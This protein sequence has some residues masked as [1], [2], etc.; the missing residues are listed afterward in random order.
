MHAYRMRRCD[1]ENCMFHDAL[2][3]SEKQRVL[4]AFVLAKCASTDVPTEHARDVLGLASMQA[5]VDDDLALYVFAYTLAHVHWARAHVSGDSCEAVRTPLFEAFLKA[6]VAETK[7]IIMTDRNAKFVISTWAED[8][9]FV[10]SDLSHKRKTLLAFLNT[11][12]AEVS[13]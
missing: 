6:F 1:R 13:E 3:C 8:F 5:E 2:S 10:A 9:R 12:Y 11:S 7:Y 4:T